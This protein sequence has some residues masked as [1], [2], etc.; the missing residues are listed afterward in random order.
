MNDTIQ[1][2]IDNLII[3]RQK[4]NNELLEWENKG[5]MNIQLENRITS[6]DSRIDFLIDKL[7]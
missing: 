6:I 4:V 5:M 3:D 1:T 2:L 7:Q